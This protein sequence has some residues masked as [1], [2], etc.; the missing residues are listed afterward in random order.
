MWIVKNLL[1]GT[2]TFRGLGISIS[3]KADYDLDQLGR[4]RAETSNQVLV[5]F[6]EGYLQTVFKDQA[7]LPGVTAGGLTDQQLLDRLDSFKQAVLSEL[8]QALPA[9][10]AAAARPGPNDGLDMKH[11]LSELRQVIAADMKGMLQNLKVAKLKLK[12]EKERVL[13]DE[14]LSEAEIRARLAFLDEKERE[15]EKNF[16]EIGRKTRP[17]ETATKSVVEKADL[18]SNI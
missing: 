16:S 13:V 18:L 14:S 3:P 5:A 2:L 12:E 7:G 6:E 10:V 1:R 8:R 17:S 4:Q 15:L 11:E 9:Q